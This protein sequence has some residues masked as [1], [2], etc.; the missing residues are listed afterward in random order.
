MTGKTVAQRQQQWRAKRKEAGYQMHTVWL[1]PDVAQ[2]LDSV[3]E[4]AGSKQADRQRL[5]NQYIRLALNSTAYAQEN[6]LGECG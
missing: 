6:H 5:I 2:A 3:I 1:D 4:G